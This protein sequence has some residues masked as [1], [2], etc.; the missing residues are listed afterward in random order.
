[1]VYQTQWRN[2]EFTVK[3]INEHLSKVTK[4][5]WVLEECAT[6]VPQSL[7]AARE[8]L[9]FG[10]K[11]ANLQTLLSM[12]ANDDGKLVLDDIMD[13]NPNDS[14]SALK[15]VNTLFVTIKVMSIFIKLL[16]LF[17]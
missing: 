15:M 6:R 5:E 2:S 13:Y 7:E 3:A 10:L 11:G 12:K 17:L 14:D 9:N 4:R 8:L 16:L 1:M